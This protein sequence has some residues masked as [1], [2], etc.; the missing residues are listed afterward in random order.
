MLS[1]C[2]AVSSA[3]FM[4]ITLNLYH[5]LQMWKQRFKE[6]QWLPK[7]TKNWGWGEDWEWNLGPSTLEP[8]SGS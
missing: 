7:A 4:R 3:V 6:G 5:N 2:Q 1:V 8:P